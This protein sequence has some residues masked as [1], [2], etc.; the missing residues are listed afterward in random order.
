MW[1]FS[2]KPD[3]ARPTKFTGA[4]PRLDNRWKGGNIHL[5]CPPLSPGEVGLESLQFGEAVFDPAVGNEVFLAMQDDPHTAAQEGAWKPLE[6]FA[7]CMM[8]DTSCGPIAVIVW[9]FS[10]HGQV[11]LARE[12]YLNASDARLHDKLRRAGRQSRLKLILRENRA[13]RTEGFWEFDNVYGLDAFNDA[14]MTAA[15][16]PGRSFPVRV[17]AA[18]REYTLEELMK[19]T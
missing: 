7:T 8:L 6:L 4:A 17:E 11:L 12:H 19:P 15:K 18:Q 14:L 9:K 5:V 13:G 2:R 16:A 10:V 3:T 1:P